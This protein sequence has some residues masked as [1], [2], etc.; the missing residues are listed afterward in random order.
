M[1][2]ATVA[3]PG[4]IVD[5]GAGNHRVSIDMATQIKG[6]ADVYAGQ[7]VLTRFLTETLRD[8]LGLTLSPETLVPLL[9]GRA[10]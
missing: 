3:V 2:A 7:F 9:W 1:A 6:D 5:R 10:R 8:G 4:Q